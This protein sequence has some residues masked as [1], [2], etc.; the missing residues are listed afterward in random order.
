MGGGRS[1]LDMAVGETVK[2]Q[3]G[4][5]LKI[6]LVEAFC[7][8]VMP[9]RRGKVGGVYGVA[10]RDES[11]AQNIGRLLS[12]NEAEAIGAA[13]FFMDKAFRRFNDAPQLG[14]EL[15]I[16]PG[17]VSG[18]LALLDRS[19]PAAHAATWA[20]GWLARLPGLVLTDAERAKLI[21]L[22]GEPTS[23]SE[24]VFWC[25]SI[26]RSLQD[27]RAIDPIKGRLRDKSARVRAKAAEA[28]GVFRASKVVVELGEQL[29]DA[30]LEV[31]AAAT[32]A[33]GQIG[34]AAAVELLLRMLRHPSH[35]DRQNALR[36][37]AI[38]FFEGQ[39]EQKLLTREFNAVGPY[40]DP[41][42]PIDDAQVARAAKK[43]DLSIDEIR[44]R[45]EEITH[46]IPLRL[47]W[48]ASPA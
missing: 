26:F 44:R 33:L 46:R 45:Y 37:L 43:L 15:A 47:S 48:R 12:V 9:L 7:K 23:D 20:L 21:S 6:A 40:L 17:L 31:R 2:S 3:W 28:M 14:Q 36:A 18:L 35:T 5:V 30:E 42:K 39:I 1:D 24:V 4:D 38:A 32:R 16:E 19:I 10:V 34:D 25:I 41:E 13:L 8:Q 11:I 29:T 27:A 22:I